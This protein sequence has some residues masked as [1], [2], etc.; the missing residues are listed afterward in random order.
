LNDGR[1]L[2]GQAVA[3]LEV[4]DERLVG[5]VAQWRRASTSLSESTAMRIRSAPA[6]SK[7]RI[8]RSVPSRSWVRVAAML[9]TAM[10]LFPPILTRPTVISRV[11]LSG[12]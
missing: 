3:L 7:M 2:L 11:F 5:L 1:A 8:W 9:C 6:F 10:G 4:D 12:A